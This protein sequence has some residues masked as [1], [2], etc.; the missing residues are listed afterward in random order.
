MPF[1]GKYFRMIE[2]TLFATQLKSTTSLQ[3]NDLNFNIC[4]S[5]DEATPTFRRRFS[6][7]IKMPVL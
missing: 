7:V 6:P 5:E 4:L 3:F 1:P 2:V